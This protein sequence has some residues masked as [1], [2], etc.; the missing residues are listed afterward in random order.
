MRARKYRGTSEP[1]GGC[2]DV[3]R[4]LCFCFYAHCARTHDKQKHFNIL[5]HQLNTKPTMS[6]SVSVVVPVYPPHFHL[7]PQ[8]VAGIMESTVLPDE[9]VIGASELDDARESTM[10][11]ELLGIVDSR[12]PVLI[13]A[14][15]H[16]KGYSGFNRNRGVAKCTSDVIFFHD[17][18]DPI[19]RQK[20]EIVKHCFDTYPDCKQLIHKL[21][22]DRRELAGTCDMNTLPF[23][24]YTGVFAKTA[25]WKMHHLCRGHVAVRKSV[26]EKIGFNPNALNQQDNTFCKKVHAMFNQTYFLPVCLLY[27]VPTGPATRAQYYETHATETESE[28]KTETET[29]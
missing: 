3:D 27:Y 22:I 2:G 8:C 16:N 7:L 13:I 19:H 4:L 28:T 10:R 25:G 15:T 5:Y 6:A 29:A 11:A 17:A 23:Y 21:C 9:I 26:F 24:H 12:G 18:D 1:G 20:V 14:S